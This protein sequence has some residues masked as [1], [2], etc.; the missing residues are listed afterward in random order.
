MIWQWYQTVFAPGSFNNNITLAQNDLFS[1]VL[2][3]FLE[4]GPSNQLHIAYKCF[5]S[6]G[7]TTRSRRIIQMSQKRIFEWSKEP[8]KRFLAVFLSL[9][10]WSDLI[11]HIVIA[12]YVFQLWAALPGH[13]GSFKDHKNA[14]LDDPKSQKRGF[15][16]FT[17]VWSVGSSWYW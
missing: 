8:K 1:P 2:G 10:C 14:F 5:P 3:H 13:M 7:N 16:P 11:W 4:F 15:W 17:W 12:L 9:V 6:F